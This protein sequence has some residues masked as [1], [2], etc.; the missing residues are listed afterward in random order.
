MTAARATLKWMSEIDVCL[1]SKA[2]PPKAGK[3]F[4]DLYP[5]DFDDFFI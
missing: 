1:P 3:L 5:V 4:G 2:Y